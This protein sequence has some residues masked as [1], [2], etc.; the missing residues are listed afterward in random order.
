MRLKIVFSILL[1]VLLSILIARPHFEEPTPTYETEQ[2]FKSYIRADSLHGFDVEKYE[3]YLSIDDQAQY[4]NGNVI[5]TVTAEENL[6]SIEWDLCG[7][8]ATAV[9][10]NGIMQNNFSQND[11]HVII[12]LAG[13]SNGDQFSTTVYYS[14]NPS[15]SPSPYGCGMFFRTGSVFTISDPDASRYWWPCYDHPW[16]KALVDL[17][18]TVRDDWVAACNGLRDSIEDNG[19]GTRTHHWLGSNPMTTYLACIT[20][21]NYQELPLQYY[22][23]IPIQDFVLPNQVANATEDLSRLPDMMSAFSQMFG[24]YPFEKYGQTTVSM[25]VYGAMEH[26]TMTTLNSY[27][28]T[29][30]HL[31]DTTYAHELAHQWFGNCLSVLTFKDIWLSEGFATYSEALWTE[32]DQGYEAMCEYFQ[33]NISGYYLSY[34]NSH[35]PQTTYDPAFNAIFTPVSYEKPGSVL[36]M[37]RARVGNEMFFD[38]LQSWFQE[39]HNGNVITSEFQAKCE[40]LTGEDFSQFFDQWIYGSGI[41]ELEYSVFYNYNLAIPRYKVYAKSISNTDTEFVLDIPFHYNSPTLADSSLVQ[42]GPEVT[43]SIVLLNYIPTGYSIDPNNWMLLRGMTEKRVE[44]VD[45]YAGVSSARVSWSPYW[46]DVQPVGYYIY[47]ATFD[48]P[49]IL[50]TIEPITGTEWVDSDLSPETEYS[51]YVVAV[52]NQGFESMPSETRI[53]RTID[54]PM[55]QGMLV[56]DETRDL[57]GTILSP[58]DLQVDDFYRT[59]F[60]DM[61]YTEYDYA[62]QGTITSQILGQYSTVFWH[63]DDFTELL[64][65]DNLNA[66]G[67]YILEGGNLILS[68]FKI[69]GQ[70]DQDF[71]TQYFPNLTPIYAN[72]SVFEYAYSNEYPS[73]IIDQ[74]K[75]PA[76]WNQNL[77]MTY[78]FPNY[79]ENAIYNA[80]YSDTEPTDGNGVIIATDTGGSLTISGIPL[81]M[82]EIDGVRSFLNQYIA[83]IDESVS[84]NEQQQELGVIAINAYPNPFNPELNI[85]I[86]GLSDERVEVSIYNV[87]GQKVMALFNDVVK[88][89]KELVWSGRDSNNHKMGSG[90]YFV[91]VKTDSV[92]TTRKIILLK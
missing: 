46:T 19:D 13:I 62:S 57:G 47:R 12:P 22:N 41:P 23:D 83:S 29:G 81:Y 88:G 39:H 11:T 87:K 2:Y 90:I 7:L 5:A 60:E 92:A 14:G 63:N 25:G 68:G 66:L 73:L 79:S 33:D 27:M 53:V 86:E 17:H 31:Y 84:N 77:R 28:I 30:T 80:D 91:K 15:L 71:L 55:D 37:L 35:G 42:A 24:E 52:D 20:A 67:S 56:V 65:N 85:K 26:Q 54:M 72:N 9:E 49:F 32:Y 16:D 1:L 3:I 78:S 10:V 4:I 70:I 69:A 50:Q 40:E 44:I 76:N 82:F 18:V 75:L 21:G 58:N 48:G 61:I 45:A 74:S 34:A 89:S 38:I 6:Q 8:T 51:Y 64:I 36:H 43:E 59:I